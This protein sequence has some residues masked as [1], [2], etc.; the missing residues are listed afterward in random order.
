MCVCVWY[1]PPKAPGGKIA[2]LDGEKTTT[3]KKKRTSG[4]LNKNP[5]RTRAS[6]P[7]RAGPATT[8][9]GPTLSLVQLMA[10]A[11]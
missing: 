11:L 9:F 6:R 3:R 5:G 10:S 1:K 2:F 7:D 8:G 4:R